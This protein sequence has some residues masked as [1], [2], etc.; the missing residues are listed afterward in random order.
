MQSVVIYYANYLTY[1]VKV[2]PFQETIAWL[3]EQGLSLR[4]KHRMLEFLVI[5]LLS[6]P[7]MD[8]CLILF[9]PLSGKWSTESFIKRIPFGLNL[10]ENQS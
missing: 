9:P 7:S 1:K 3:V 4:F 5:M 8:I 10:N 2:T 6:M